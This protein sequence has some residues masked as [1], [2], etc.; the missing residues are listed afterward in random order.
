MTH[1]GPSKSKIPIF[2]KMQNLKNPS[3]QI[4]TP[5]FSTIYTCRSVNNSKRTATFKHV[6]REMPKMVKKQRMRSSST[7]CK[8]TI[9]VFF[10]TN[11]VLSG[12]KK[13]PII[14]SEAVRKIEIVHTLSCQRNVPSLLNVQ[15]RPSLTVSLYLPLC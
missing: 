4:V 13:S 11:I 14:S 9:L 3:R 7:W 6:T 12:P 5:V 2:T 8:Q 1:V 15:K 10:A